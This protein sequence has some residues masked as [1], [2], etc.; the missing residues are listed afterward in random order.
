M[1]EEKDVKSL[2][3]LPE[4]ETVCRKCRGRATGDGSG[5]KCVLCGGSGYETTEFG[6]KV[7]RLMRHRFRPLFRELISGE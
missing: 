7:V 5:G 4:L 1:S 3:D 6:E 2:A